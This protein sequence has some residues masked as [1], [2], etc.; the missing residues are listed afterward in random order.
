[1]MRNLQATFQTSFLMF[2]LGGAAVSPIPIPSSSTFS[3]ATAGLTTGTAVFWITNAVY[4]GAQTYPPGGSAWNT[5][6]FNFLS[7][8]S[9]GNTPVGPYAFPIQSASG[10][11]GW[12]ELTYG[13][14]ANGT[15]MCFDSGGVE[16]AIG[17]DD[18]L[19]IV[20]VGEC[21][22]LSL[23]T[24]LPVQLT[25]LAA[26]T[27]DNNIEVSW[28]T[29]VE[30]NN[31]GFEVQRSSD[32]KNFQKLGFI[33]GKLNSAQEEKYAFLDRTVQANTMYY[34]RLKQMDVNGAFEISKTVTGK[35]D[36]SDRFS[37]SDIY[38]NPSTSQTIRFDINVPSAQR[39]SVDV[40]DA[41]GAKLYSSDHD[42]F[43]GQNT[44]EL[45]L[46]GIPA[47]AYF[48]KIVAGENTKYSKFVIQ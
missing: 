2:G 28:L 9:S 30:V 19:G 5:V 47:G 15:V 14:G 45:N 41:Y 33:Q 7:S 48:A 18:G 27:V 29:Q 39:L 37:V 3:C 6:S 22:S 42:T 8:S 44:I 35:V 12:V 24:V 23:P 16:D 26:K 17:G 34:Y 46:G 36:A 32:G 10:S 1:M 38:P 4:T 21:E 13:Y 20:H 25:D 43:A 31:N 11:C 40:F